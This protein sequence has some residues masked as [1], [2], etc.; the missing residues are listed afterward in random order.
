[1]LAIAKPGATAAKVAGEMSVE[2]GGVVWLPPKVTVV[3]PVMPPGAGTASGSEESSPTDVGDM[4]SPAVN[5]VLG[6]LLVIATSPS[7]FELSA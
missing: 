2:F 3:A 1:M 6:G 5:P 7:C 4:A